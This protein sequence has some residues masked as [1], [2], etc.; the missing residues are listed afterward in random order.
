M[1]RV[2]SC[3]CHDADDELTCL[4]GRLSSNGKRYPSDTCVQYANMTKGQIF[5]RIQ[6]NYKMFSGRVH[7]L[8][9][10]VVCKSNTQVNPSDSYDP[11]N[12]K[13]FRFG[14]KNKYDHEYVRN[15]EEYL[16]MLLCLV[17][18][19]NPELLEKK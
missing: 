5:D 19:K 7:S 2:S 15:L 4:N 11:N 6:S 9:D 12:S 16:D 13:K 3:E 10:G 14:M 18:E 8:N 17:I 1:D